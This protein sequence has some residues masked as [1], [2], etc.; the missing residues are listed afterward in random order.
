MVSIVFNTPFLFPFI[1][2][3]PPPL[4]LLPSV[5]FSWFFFFILFHHS[6]PFLRYETGRERERESE[7]KGERERKDVKE[8]GREDREEALSVTCRL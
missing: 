6:F 5:L 3:L 7:R 4:L 8:G 2:F 1:T